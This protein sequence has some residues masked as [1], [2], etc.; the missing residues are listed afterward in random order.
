[1][2]KNPALTAKAH[3][4]NGSFANF[5]SVFHKNDIEYKNYSD[6]LHKKIIQ[7][8]EEHKLFTKVDSLKL[9]Y[10]LDG[11]YFKAEPYIKCV[12]KNGTP[13]IIDDL[14]DT[15]VMMTIKIIPYDLIDKATKQ[16]R[17]GIMCK[18]TS[19]KGL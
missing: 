3:L 13:C 16:R 1:M 4:L 12:N 5:Y 8:T 17:T 9:P 2:Q 7:C 18:V 11:F 10:N 6:P 19:I 15:D 14:Y